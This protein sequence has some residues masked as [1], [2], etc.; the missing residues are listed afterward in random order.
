MDGP[1]RT[2]AWVAAAAIGALAPAAATAGDLTVRVEGLRSADGA[3]LVAVCGPDTFTTADCEHAA[4][5]EPGA[6][7]TIRG[8]PPGRWAVQAIHD[9][10]RDGT[11]NRRLLLPT[12][13]LA[14]SRDA[15]M[16]RGP[17][18]FDDAAL[19]VG[20]EGG[21]VTLTMRYFQ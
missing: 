10:N 15:P 14:F 6:A 17:P 7:V 20:P 13:G 5:A 8:V 12:E 3:V 2:R 18:A 4:R 9:E 19:A 21:T 11:L 1:A 16:R